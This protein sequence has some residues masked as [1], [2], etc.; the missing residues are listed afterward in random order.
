M[1]II[2]RLIQI[3]I[4]LGS[5]IPIEIDTDPP[6]TITSESFGPFE[7][8][9]PNT[10][11]V[12]KVDTGDSKNY[13]VAFTCGPSSSDIRYSS[14][15]SFNSNKSGYSLTIN[16]PTYMLLSPSGMFCKLVITRTKTGYNK[17]ITFTINPIS[18]YQNI[19]PS[20]YTKTPYK[21]NNA[22]Y[23]FVNNMLWPGMEQY[24][25]P[26]YIDYLNIDTYYRLDLKDVTFNHFPIQEYTYESAF[27][28]VSDFMNI[29]PYIPHDE[30]NY[31]SI[32]LNITYDNIICHFGFAN[33]M[34][35]HP[36][37]LQMSLRYIDG[38]VP[39]H[40][41]YLPVNK[42]GEMLEEKVIVCIQGGGLAKS[43][44]SWN[45]SYLATNNMIGHCSNSDYCVVGGMQDD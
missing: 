32:P 31:I 42:K 13:S 5:I 18:Y 41:F 33:T 23:S 39:T 17:T 16:L 14:N 40:H 28:K 3:F 6:I 7:A 11:I 22:F 37:T 36:K 30:D 1:S 12:L 19:D 45:L 34:Y 2:S 15:S 24:T 4:I 29:F 8:Y 25:F 35:V 26:N 44:I 10:D 9:Q 38:F 21:I 43:N 20:V 27:M